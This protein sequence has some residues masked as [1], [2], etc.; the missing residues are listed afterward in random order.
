MCVSGVISY[1]D[2]VV[3]ILV[4]LVADMTCG[5][6]GQVDLFDVILQ[7]VLGYKLLLT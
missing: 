3:Q 4:F 6:L 2:M 7:R 1:L 5:G